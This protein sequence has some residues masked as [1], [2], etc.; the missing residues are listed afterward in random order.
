M[1]IETHDDECPDCR[2]GLMDP[3]THEVLPDDHPVMKSVLAGWAMTSVEERQ[4]FHRFCCQ[5]SRDP[6]DLELVG[7]VQQ[8]IQLAVHRRR[9]EA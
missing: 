3:E 2:P 8:R 4:A 1:S 9:G 7:R 6:N 5:N